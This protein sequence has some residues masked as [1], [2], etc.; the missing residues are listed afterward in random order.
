M[1]DN[2]IEST[3]KKIELSDNDKTNFFK[4]FLADKPYTES[5]PKFNG[6]FT[7][8]FRT[9]TANERTDIVNQVNLDKE[10]GIGNNN[11]YYITIAA[12]EAGLA[13]T[14]LNSVPF[15]PDIT[16]EKF[17]PKEGD[18]FTSY[19]RE[20]AAALLQW[21]DFKL[22]TLLDAHNWFTRKVMTLM[23]AVNDSNF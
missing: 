2:K 16:K 15:Q 12:Y 8:Q 18:K 19:V 7:F 6:K 21:Q 3:D 17:T 13:L 5:V 20:R 10:A 9:L 4:A 14:A 22:S 1:E 23:E 11:S